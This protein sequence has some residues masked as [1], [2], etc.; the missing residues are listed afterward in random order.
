MH[1]PRSVAEILTLVTT[2]PG[3]PRVTWYGDGGERIE[4]S[5]AV[6]ANWVSKTTN[7]LVEEFDAGPGVRVGVDLPAHW[8]T[9]VWALAAWRCG[10][11]VVLGPGAGSADVVV[12]DRPGL[13]PG[14]DELVAVALPGLARRFDGELP[15]GAIDA[16]GAVMTYGDAIGWTPPVAP[17]AVA[18]EADQPPP[19]AAGS[20]SVVPHAALVAWAEEGAGAVSG[21][22]VLLAAGTGRD[23]AVVVLLQGVL[24]AL[25][26]AGSVVLV[27]DTVAAELA[28]DPARRARLVAS[29]RVS[30]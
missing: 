15:A 7:L 5:G 17:D 24:A 20:P 6:L 18:V 19:G 29:E 28:A 16:A 21:A 23:G 8:R 3:R 30:G 25:A 11:G 10:A 2:D 14:A 26:H 13:H 27:A 12:T 1:S 22:R 4:L 9:V